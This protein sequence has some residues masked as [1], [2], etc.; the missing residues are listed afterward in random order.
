MS[1]TPTTINTVLVWS[2]VQRIFEQHAQQGLHHGKGQHEQGAREDQSA[3]VGNAKQFEN[4][5]EGIELMQGYGLAA[6]IK[7][8][9]FGH[10][11]QAPQ[12]VEQAQARRQK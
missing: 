6:L 7:K 2:P 9:G 12:Q 4:L 11:K 8:V 1:D 10:E 3:D 5:G